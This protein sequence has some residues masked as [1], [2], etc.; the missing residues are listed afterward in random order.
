M[1]IDKLLSSEEN[2]KPSFD[3]RKTFLQEL[4]QESFSKQIRNNKH[5]SEY[6]SRYGFIEKTILNNIDNIPLIP[7]V[8]FKKS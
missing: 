7:S 2:F 3:Q 1:K 6:C 8:L 5:Y 4:L